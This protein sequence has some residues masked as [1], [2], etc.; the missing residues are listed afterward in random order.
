MKFCFDAAKSVQAAATILKAVGGELDMYVF[1]KIIYLSDRESLLKWGRP[2]TGDRM[3]AM[4]HGPVPSTCYALTKNGQTGE[5]QESW[6]RYVRKGADHT[7]RLEG[8]PGQE[9]LSEFEIETLQRMAAEFGNYSFRQM[10]DHAHALPEFV[11]VGKTSKT[12]WPEE[13]MAANEKT[14]EFISASAELLRSNQRMD[15]ILAGF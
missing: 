13:V 11:D 9:D 7:V 14:D 4:E 5:E 3:V 12:M 1:L 8:D 15:S 10:R 6:L 2:I